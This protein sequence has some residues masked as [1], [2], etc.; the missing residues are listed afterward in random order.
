MH[1]WMVDK[2]YDGVIITKTDDRVRTKDHQVVVWTL[3][4]GEIM[5]DKEIDALLRGATVHVDDHAEIWTGCQYAGKVF[6][7]G[8]HRFPDFTV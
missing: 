6:K 2:K 7:V 4:A 5:T 1:Y 8:K 3:T